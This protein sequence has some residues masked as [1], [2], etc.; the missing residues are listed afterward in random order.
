MDACIVVDAVEKSTGLSRELLQ[1]SGGRFAR[2]KW[3]EDDFAAG[4]L[5]GA[6]FGLIESLE[7]VIAA[8]GVDVGLG[9]GE[10]IGGAHVRENADRIDRLKSGENGGAIRFTVHRPTFAFE[11]ADGSIAVHADEEHVTMITGVLKVCDVAEMQEI[12]AA[13]RDDH[14]FLASELL[15]PFG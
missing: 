6:T 1:Q 4:L 13:V 11:S 3:D 2:N 15:A 14:A 5:D 9:G 12:E 7:R 8:F 10:E